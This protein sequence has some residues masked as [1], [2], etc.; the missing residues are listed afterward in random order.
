[1]SLSFYQENLHQPPIQRREEPLVISVST[2]P[3]AIALT[4][5]LGANS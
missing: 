2:Y 5:I 1:M 3:G 4:R